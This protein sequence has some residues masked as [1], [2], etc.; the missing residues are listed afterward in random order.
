[1]FSIGG[2]GHEILLGLLVKPQ[3]KLKNSF[4]FFSLDTY[5][6]ILNTTLQYDALQHLFPYICVMHVD[7]VYQFLVTEVKG[8]FLHICFC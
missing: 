4:F 8:R 2:N 7:Q 5:L 6:F 3:P 1:M